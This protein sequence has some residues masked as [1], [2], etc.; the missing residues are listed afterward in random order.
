[1]GLDY[2]SDTS[3]EAQRQDG[4]EGDFGA[5]VDL[6]L[7]YDW[8]W[9]D[10]EENVGDDVYDRVPEADKGVCAVGKTMRAGSYAQFEV[11]SCGYWCALEEKCARTRKRKASE[12]DYTRQRR[13]MSE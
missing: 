10:G 11:P 5:L 1:M 4:D 8:N 6:E 7:Q 12:K 13:C 3:D 2:A 9:N